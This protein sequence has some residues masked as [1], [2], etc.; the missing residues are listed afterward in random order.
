MDRE[1][2][3][4]SSVDL[5]PTFCDLAGITIPQGVQGRSIK[6]VALGKSPEDWREYVI[7]ESGRGRMVR[8][9]RYKY[10]LYKDGEPREMLIDM[11]NDP[12]EMKNLAANPKFRNVLVAHR[13]FLKQ[14]NKLTGN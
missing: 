6:S 9:A 10:N 2:L 5:I 4:S 1:H 11:V 8:S 13:E 12:G 3:V 14:W 7:S